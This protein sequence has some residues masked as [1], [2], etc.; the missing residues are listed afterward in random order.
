MPF[1]VRK[2]GRGVLE[3][4]TKI[5][6][7]KSI[8][9]KNAKPYFRNLKKN[10]SLTVIWHEKN[11]FVTATK[12]GTTNNFFVA[13]AKNFAAVTKRFIDRSKHFVVVTKYFFIPILTNVFVGITKTFF[14]WV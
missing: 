11:G 9:G 10:L 8:W 5:N 3:I 12:L 14:P 4:L 6:Y 1:Y 7:Q 13:T 2:K